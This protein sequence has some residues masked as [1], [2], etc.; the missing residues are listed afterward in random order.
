MLQ[1]RIIPVLLL[2]NQVLH[3]TIRFKNIFY[4]GDPINAIRIFNEKEVDELAFIDI[5]ASKSGNEPNYKMIESIASECFMPLC[6]GGGI[7]NIEQARRIFSIGVEK[8][9]L[10][11]VLFDKPSLITEISEIYGNQSIIC[12]IDIKKS[13]F[14]KYKV[15]N[16]VKKQICE[17]DP[18][19]YAKNLEKLGAGEL[20]INM[21]DDDGTMHGYNV[22]FFTKFSACFNIPV[23]A[24]GGAGTINHF[25]ELFKSSEVSAAA[26]GS[27]FVFHGKHK[28]VLI[29]YP[30]ESDINSITNGESNE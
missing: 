4:V 26:A 16:H 27:M 12:S 30:Q 19:K 15:F 7:K 10:N 29:T 2:H 11:S 14:S 1:K 20:L 24:C 21:V 28:A 13:I 22:S 23:I 9:I 5:D 17:K 8:I 6:Y 3:K 25:K 18:Y